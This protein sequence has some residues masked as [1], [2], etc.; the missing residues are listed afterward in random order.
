MS[1]DNVRGV[2]R[3]ISAG[4]M[5]ASWQWKWHRSHLLP[6]S[7]STTSP[8]H[9]SSSR[10]LPTSS[11]KGHVPTHL[12]DWCLHSYPSSAPLLMQ[13]CTSKCLPD[14]SPGWMLALQQN[15]IPTE[16]RGLLGASPPGFPT[17]PQSPE[18]RY[19]GSVCKPSHC[20]IPTVQFTPAIPLT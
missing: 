16:G 14:A 6:G 18:P 11:V 15:L 8:G 3:P 9:L 5:W 20:F 1:K 10:F 13:I 4:V 19:K 17:T 12:L 7:G 2:S